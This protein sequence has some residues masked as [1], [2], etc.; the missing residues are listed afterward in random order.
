M[1][2]FSA[3][4]YYR[5]AGLTHGQASTI[6]VS[7]AI[8]AILAVVL[9]LMPV[10]ELSIWTGAIILS[11]TLGLKLSLSSLFYAWWINVRQNPFDD[12]PERWGVSPTDSE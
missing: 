12:I 8:V 1:A 10:L 7:F 6:D 11:A 3:W 9:V 4:T 5:R 2:V